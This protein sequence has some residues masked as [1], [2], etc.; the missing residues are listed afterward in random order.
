L[1]VVRC[2][3]LVASGSLPPF[4]GPVFLLLRFFLSPSW[5]RPQHQPAH[6]WFPL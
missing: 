3:V 2:L 5:R 6:S 4:S 1:C